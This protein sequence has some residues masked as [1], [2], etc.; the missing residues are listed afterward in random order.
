MVRTAS[1]YKVLLQTLA[2][3][4]FWRLLDLFHL[5]QI[6]TVMVRLLS[7]TRYDYDEILITWID[8]VFNGYYIW[9]VHLVGL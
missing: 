5:T 1:D 8:L 6:L 4:P 3:I 7:M 2:I 9:S